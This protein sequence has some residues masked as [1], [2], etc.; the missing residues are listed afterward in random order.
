VLYGKYYKDV[1]EAVA[2]S[3]CGSDVAELQK[4]MKVRMIIINSNIG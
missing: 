4:V 3:L 1:R 2:I